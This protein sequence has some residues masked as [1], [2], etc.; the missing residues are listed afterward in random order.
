M[1][2]TIRATAV[3]L[4]VVAG[5][6]PRAALAGMP[7]LTLTDVAHARLETISFFLLLILLSAAA[8]KFLWNFLRADLAKRLPP[9]TYGKSLALVGLWG[10][11]FIL[12]LTMISGAR[13]LLTPGAW[14][15]QGATY[16]LA[17]DDGKDRKITEA[18]RRERLEQL[19]AALWTYA[20]GHNGA[21]PAD[22][23]DIAIP[24]TLWETP[25]TSRVRY[26]YVRGRKAD[27]GAEPVVYEPTAFGAPRLVLM[28]NGEIQRVGDAELQSMLAVAGTGSGAAR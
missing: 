18:M 1:Q 14:E 13:E 12:V 19:K 6:F 2:R 25:E 8:V 27:A 23:R 3:A 28:S 5:M 16:K 11:L 21:F 20:A 26:E 17:K 10:A 7:S 24:A 4:V 15:K 22:D 9:L